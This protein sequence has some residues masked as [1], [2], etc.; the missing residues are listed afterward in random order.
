M[1][2][3]QVSYLNPLNDYGGVEK[4]VLDLSKMLSSGFGFSVDILCADISEREIDGPFG[5]IFLLKTPLFK[6]RGVFFIAKYLY[7]KRVKN[8]LINRFKDYDVIHFHGD[9]GLIDKKYSNISILTLHGVAIIGSSIVSKIIS[10]LPYRIEKNNVKNA[11]FV[12]SVSKEAAGYFHKIRSDIIYIKQSIDTSKYHVPNKNE[13]KEARTILGFNDDD[14][15]GIII[16]REP[17]RKGLYIA[18]NAIMVLSDDRIKLVAIGF[19][20]P[21]NSYEKVLFTGDLTED[22]KLLYLFAADFFILPS[23][24]EGFPIS[25]LE[26]ATCGLS[27][28]VSN[29]AGV[30]ELSNIVPFYREIS[31]HDPNDYKSA[32]REF[33][34]YYSNSY[35]EKESFNNNKLSQYSNFNMAAIYVDAYRNIRKSVNKGIT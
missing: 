2:V 10:Y 30:S 17:K 12:F 4:Y 23:A 13:R 28:I 24:K 16:G 22:K 18:I 15:I 3:L 27:L 32:L 31:S 20:V 9:N 1:K 26:A 7:G 34:A 6:R 11:K 33:I 14:I 8:F 29:Q 35:F 21:P 19:P 5:K 25:A